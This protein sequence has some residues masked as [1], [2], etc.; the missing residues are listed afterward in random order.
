MRRRAVLRSIPALLLLP[1]LVTAGPG[2]EALLGETPGLL[3][4]MEAKDGRELLRIDR[5]E[6]R[7]PVPAGS[8]VKPF[9][10]LAW[11]RGHERRDPWSARLLEGLAHR[12]DV[13]EATLTP[14][15]QPAENVVAAALIASD[16]EDADNVIA[17]ALAAAPDQSDAIKAAAVR[18]LPQTS[19]GVQAVAA[20]PM[21]ST[22]AK[23]SGGG[24]SVTA[25]DVEGLQATLDDIEAQLVAAGVEVEEAEAQVA[26]LTASLS[27]SQADLATATT[28]LEQVQADIEA[29]QA[30]QE[31]LVVAAAEQAAALAAAA[32]KIHQ[33]NMEIIRLKYPR[34]LHQL[35]SESA[36]GSKPCFGVAFSCSRTV[37]LGWFTGTCLQ[38]FI[39][40]FMV[41]CHICS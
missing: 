38:I 31:A 12:G 36:T 20:S 35:Q 19:Q 33:T 29:A 6:H 30:A 34:S 27:E 13:G 16:G 4:A 15:V 28:A 40:T 8:L 2:P 21:R 7:G 23:S 18:V 5:R 3:L 17:A 25:D 1:F 9:T 14:G 39:C 11:S 41:K 32:E 26:S 37:L 22:T 10:F 24:A